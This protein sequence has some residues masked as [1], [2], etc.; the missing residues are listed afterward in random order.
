MR[1]QQ[2]QFLL[3]VEATQ[4]GLRYR[5]E[6]RTWVATC[7]VRRQGQTWAQGVLEV[8]EA[9]ELEDAFDWMCLRLGRELFA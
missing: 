9:A 5:P 3:A 6:S 4:C 8:H 7:Y 1:D 2:G